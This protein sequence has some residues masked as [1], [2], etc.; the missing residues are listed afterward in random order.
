MCHHKAP[1]R[2]WEPHP[3]TRKLYNNPI[4]IPET[5]TDDYRHRAKA[6]KVAKMRVAEDL[7]YF[8]LGLSQPEGGAREVGELVE[9]SL[10]RKVPFPET[11]AEVREMKLFDS[12]TG[13]NYVFEGREALR[14]FKYQR[15]MQRY[16]RC[17]HSVDESVGDLLDYLD[18]EGLAEDTVVMYTS[19][20]G[21]L[22]S[23]S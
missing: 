22:P 12:T 13:E 2:S 19:D 9:G 16:L 21:K 5:F 8:D 20:Q 1:H 7:T 4:K 14:E 11:E 17:V 3:S 10:D 15:Y 18:D 23:P 6:A